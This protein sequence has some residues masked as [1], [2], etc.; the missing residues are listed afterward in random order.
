MNKL[1]VV[2]C[3]A[4]LAVVIYLTNNN[5]TNCDEV[6]LLPEGGVVCEIFIRDG[7]RYEVLKTNTVREADRI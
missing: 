3:C 4:I 5:A 6:V 7:A 2:S 1:L